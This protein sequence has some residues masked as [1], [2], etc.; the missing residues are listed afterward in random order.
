V[1]AP[2]EHDLIVRGLLGGVIAGAITSVSR[3]A[4]RLS[5]SGQWAAFFAGILAAAAGWAWAGALIAFFATATLLTGWRAAEKARLTER[6]LP[7][8][9]QRDGKQVLANGGVFVLLALAA[10]ATGQGRLAAGALGAL[11]AASADTW[12]TEIGTL[13]GGTP[14]SILSWR[15]LATGLSGGVTRIGSLAGLAG[16][17][18]IGA[19]GVLMVADGRLGFVLAVTAGG[20]I[21]SIAD[22][23]IGA[24]MQSKRYC[25]RCEEWTERRVHPCG[26]RTKHRAGVSWMSNDVVNLLGSCAGALA[27]MVAWSLAHR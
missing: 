12:S 1:G 2:I 3:R 23:M 21:G 7:H 9:T 10:H 17:A 14:R 20:V 6:T 26:Y 16:A 8:S 18:F 19:F 4:E 15:P 5:T 13:F 25:D 22:S 27:A 11:A 24:A